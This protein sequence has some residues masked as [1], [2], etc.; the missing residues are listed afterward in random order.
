MPSA[1][2]MATLVVVALEVTMTITAS[3]AGT[4]FESRWPEPAVPPVSLPR[5][6]FA[7]ATDRA[8]QPA[9][10]DG[11]TGQ[12]TSYGE[13]ATRVRRAAAGFAAHGLGK[14]QVVAILAPNQPDWL[15]CAYG[16]TTAGGVVS[17][18]NALST[19]NE[20]AAHLRDSGARF[21][22]AAPAL[23]GVARA[24]IERAGGGVPIVLLG[25][26]APGTVA[27]AELLA[28]G[29]RPP[30]A[31]IDPAVDL[32]LLPYSSGTSG[33]PKGVMLTHR[34]CVTNVLQQLAAFPLL[35][36]D[37][38]LAVAPFSHA[39]GFSVV[40]NAALHAGATVVTVPRFEIEAFLRL[41]EQHR[42]TATIVAPPIVL[43]LAKHPAVDHYDLSSLE[44]V[45][46]GAAPLGAGLQQACADRLGRPVVQGYGMTEV[47]AGAALWPLDTPVVPGAAGHLLPGVQARIVDLASGFDLGPGETGELWLRSA[48][49]MAGYF[50]DAAATAA[51]VD[52]DGW[53]HT[54]DIARI[55]A[56]GALFVVD[57][58][59]ELIKVKGFQVAPAELEALLRTHPGIAEA[60]VVGIPDERA[61]ERPKAFVVR[62]SGV[63]LTTEEVVAYVA[64]RVAPHKRVHAVEFID[65]IPTSPA[66]KTLRRMLRDR[67]GA[68][69]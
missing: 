10:V 48:A 13:L 25:A 36:R 22:V 14:G 12:V 46:C 32:A 30:Q 44:W 55:D 67:T 31:A 60:A 33:L 6:L 39:I 69:R 38:V 66:G 1:A 45:G 28:H 54:G 56:D 5:F 65:A 51:T 4:V 17:G 26:A 29:D 15:A 63:A 50:R 23:L 41:V 37:R 59:K 2:D 19:P 9:L 35:P 27:F 11:A 34:A 43:A 49:A 58:V 8:G 20:V 52:P 24:A 61:G 7:T 42:I 3:L 68:K 21:L 47:T 18:I 40:A 57:R 62:A 53:L 16:A 64:E